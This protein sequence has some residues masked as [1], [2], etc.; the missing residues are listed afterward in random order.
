MSVKEAHI[1]ES[2]SVVGARE[3][4]VRTKVWGFHRLGS[5]SYFTFRAAGLIQDPKHKSLLSEA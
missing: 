2:T 4:S 3:H 5:K 1:P